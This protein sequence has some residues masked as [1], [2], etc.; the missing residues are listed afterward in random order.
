MDIAHLPLQGATPVICAAL[1][2]RVGQ[3][4][5]RGRT[6]RRVGGREQKR[7]TL[8]RSHH[9]AAPRLCPHRGN[10]VVEP[11]AC[12]AYQRHSLRQLHL[13]ERLL[14]QGARDLA[15]GLVLGHVGD[16][17]ERPL[18]N[19]QGHGGHRPGE[20][21][22]EGKAVQQVAEVGATWSLGP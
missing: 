20:E 6:A 19:A 22:G 12:G 15:G 18:R 13:K 9:L 2:G 14:T 3:L 7:S 8:R 16:L 10:D 21:P 11:G 5:R 17:V 4:H 1:T